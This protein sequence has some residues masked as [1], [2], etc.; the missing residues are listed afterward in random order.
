MDRFWCC[1]QDS[2]TSIFHRL[3]LRK[4][5]QVSG[6]S[7]K[8]RERELD[9]QIEAWIGFCAV[10]FRLLYFTFHKL[11]LRK[12]FNWFNYSSLCLKEVQ[13]CFVSK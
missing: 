2:C 11:E 7:K 8:E 1:I 10:D 9:T 12:S 6:G 3:K 13:S 4:S 5:Q